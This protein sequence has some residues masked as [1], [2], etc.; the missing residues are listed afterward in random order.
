MPERLKCKK[1]E[2]GLGKRFLV[3]LGLSTAV[4]GSRIGAH[5]A[6]PCAVQYDSV[7]CRAV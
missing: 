3:S 6:V 2:I 4:Q 5:H 7:Q 1:P